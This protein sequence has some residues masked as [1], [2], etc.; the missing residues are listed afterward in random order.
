MTTNH[1]YNQPPKG[2]EDW[3]IPLNENFAK[4]DVD[5]EV[6][7]TNANRTDYDPT[8][9][10]K[11]LATDTGD[12]Y[13]GDGSAWLNIGNVTSGVGSPAG[14]DVIIADT[15]DE[16][17]PAI[18]KLSGDVVDGNIRA[19]HVQLRAKAYYPTDTI[20]MK[21][22]VTLRGARHA[23]QHISVGKG[24]DI[25]QTTLFTRDM[26]EGAASPLPS[27][28]VNS[29]SHFD[30]K[31]DHD[32]FFATYSSMPSA[33]AVWEYAHPHFAVING[34]DRLPL[35]EEFRTR[36]DEEAF[37]KGDGAG[38]MNLR[39]FAD[40]KRFWDP[41]GEDDSS[42]GSDGLTDAE[43]ATYFGVYDGLL[44]ENTNE[45]RIQDVH[46]HGFL[47]Y[48]GFYMDTRDVI[49]RGNTYSGTATDHHGASLMLSR[50]S[51]D[52]TPYVTGMWD[53]Y[54][55]G[56]TPTAKIDGHIRTKFRS[57]NWSKGRITGRDTTFLGSE[58]DYDAGNA[59]MADPLYKHALVAHT[60]QHARWS[61]YEL[62]ADQASEAKTGVV[63]RDNRLSMTDMLFRELDVGI[64]GNG[65]QDLV[66]AD[67]R[68]Q[69]NT[70]QL[71]DNWTGTW[72]NCTFTGNGVDFSQT[73]N[74]NLEG[75]YDQMVFKGSVGIVGSS[76]GSIAFYNP[77]FV[78]C[79]T[80]IGDPAGWRDGDGTL[81]LANPIGYTNE[82][83][84][85]ETQSGDGSSTSFSFAHG[86][87]ETPKWAH[88]EPSSPAARGDYHVTADGTDLAVTYSSAPPS[89]SGNL[90]WYWMAK[91]WSAPGVATI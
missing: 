43:R 59:P 87:D 58:A 33:S 21:R 35:R 5:V 61:G 23:P 81:L 1:N 32:N 66:I 49:S 88:I 24:D 63:S 64:N 90:S 48:N 50:R 40:K 70:G 37:Y 29:W 53:L 82:N 77:S 26:P 67:S 25:N 74:P 19:G 60:N 7:D 31:D 13:L 71:V 15:A 44:W 36:T 16:I 10:A 47:G 62:E 56:P 12:V 69:V 6:R 91:G 41:S 28:G 73:A 17:Q 85:S 39:I 65:Q 2:A 78:Q 9:G 14:S 11:Y 30:T 20:F 89:G 83:A 27:E 38:L 4:L 51:Q 34:Y 54:V 46:V 86:M 3:H 8:D 75:G 72:S 18:D 80:P 84:G 68:L 76:N 52:P 42:T 57:S 79:D 45:I 22:G 55:N